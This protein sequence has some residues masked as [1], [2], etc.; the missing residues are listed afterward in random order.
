MAA[1]SLPRRLF[2]R[3]A[4]VAGSRPVII[5]LLGMIAA[6]VALAAAGVVSGAIPGAIVI[7]GAGVVATARLGRRMPRS[8]AIVFLTAFVIRLGALGISLVVPLPDS[9]ADSIVFQR[10]AE[11]LVDSSWGRVAADVLNLAP[12][13]THGAFS[14]TY[15]GV[16][17]SVY[18]ITGSTN[19]ILAGVLNVA[20][21]TVIV[22]ITALIAMR[23]GGERS[24]LRAA[25]ITAVFPALVL[26]SVV[27]MREALTVLALVAGCHFAV[28]WMRRDR[29]RS[30]VYA[31]LWVLGGSLMHSGLIAALFALGVTAL[32][33]A[34]RAAGRSRRRALAA[35]A[36]VAAVG[37]FMAGSG[38]GL[39]KI[40]GFSLQDVA[41]LQALASRGN[42]AYLHGFVPGNYFDLVWQTPVRAVFFLFG[43]LALISP[44]RNPGYLLLI[45]DGLMYVALIALIARRWRTIRRSP[46]ALLLAFMA[47]CLIGMFAIGVSNFGTA[48]RHRQKIV[49]LL[50][51]LASL[52]RSGADAPTE[53][54]EQP[55]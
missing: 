20:A 13:P 34:M 24:A 23:L 14:N 22:A 42:T 7:L 29:W 55:T 4:P 27:E 25:W 43:P 2:E 12:D 52:P 18:R 40:T 19:S 9:D 48:F 46:G 38:V 5:G 33:R 15:S 47:L 39:D 30:L 10:R 26:Y 50:I 44:L 54:V 37:A 31:T 41:D 11:V 3:A 35:V 51:V 49:A 6:L 1:Q 45:V 8:L 28:D 32:V 36:V 53:V 21:G 16:L 17:A